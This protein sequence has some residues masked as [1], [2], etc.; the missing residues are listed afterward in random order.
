MLN[1]EGGGKGEG[2]RRGRKRRGGGAEPGVCKKYFV[3]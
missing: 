2:K 1:Q 3:G